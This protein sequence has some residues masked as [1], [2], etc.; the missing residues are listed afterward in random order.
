[1][2]DLVVEAQNIFPNRPAERKR[3]RSTLLFINLSKFG[4][5]KIKNRALP[6]TKTIA[7]TN[8]SNHNRSTLQITNHNRSTQYRF[9]EMKKENANLTDNSSYAIQKNQ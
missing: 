6:C 8:T 7:E 5:K 4:E 9:C 2:E 1:M 3:S